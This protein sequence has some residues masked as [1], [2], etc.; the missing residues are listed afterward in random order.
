MTSTVDD[1]LV[2][3]GDDGYEQARVGR[4]FNARRPPRY[5][6]AVLV[7]RDAEDVAAGVR[8]ARERGWPVS[9]RSGGHSW[10]AWSLRDGALL[11]D[12]GHLDGV[13]YDPSTGTA[14]AGPATK[15][16]TELAPFLAAH[17]RSF[18]GGHCPTV[19]LGGYLLQGGQGWNG[20][21]QGWAC[22]SLIAVDVVTA[23]GERIHADATQHPDL[24]WAAR[25]AGPGFPGIVTR[26]HLRTYEAPAQMWHDTWTFR[27][28][29][30]E[31][32]L[33][34]LH[35]LLP[36]LDRRAEPVL[37]ATRLPGVPVYPGL[38]HP[39]T[40][41]L[42]HTTAMVDSEAEAARLLG[43]FETGPLAGSELGHVRGPTTIEQESQAQAEQSPE[44]YRYAV[45]CAW[46][47]AP[48]SELAPLL[49]RMWGELDTEH[50]FSIWYGWAPGRV[51]PDMAFSVE[52][53]VYI[54]TYA[55]YSDEADDERYRSWVHDRTAGIASNG[56]GVYLGDTDFTRR[57]DRF[58]ADENYRRLL[59]I[60][61]RW[62]PEGRLASYL[63]ADP[64]D[65]NV[66]V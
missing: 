27:L 44:G 53:N 11:V 48:A 56:V 12:L 24:Y 26:F 10:A 47:D 40:V 8:L 9:V 52:G 61:E 21:L 30:L 22:E 33:N 64:K 65:L 37:A 31:P 19:G 25:G 17:G 51:L 20:R 15:M 38:A 46:T 45:D 58:L 35:D 16:G 63:S 36:T 13:D 32:L 5:P 60:Q 42:L 7:A 41:L 3:R 34:W 23:A 43:V 4:I 29:D 49:A 6:V 54:A 1:R 55:I 2:V 59:E 66:H 14:T 57:Q 50:S 28:E 39:G 62:D 18:P